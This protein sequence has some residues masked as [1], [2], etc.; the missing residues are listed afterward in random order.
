[1]MTKFYEIARNLG[2]DEDSTQDAAISLLS[3]IRAGKEINESY[4]K[5]CLWLRT[6]DNQR[7]SQRYLEAMETAEKATMPSLCEDILKQQD[8]NKH[9]A[10]ELVDRVLERVKIGKKVTNKFVKKILHTKKL[11]DQQKKE[12]LEAMFLKILKKESNEHSF[13]P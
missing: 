11:T 3:N 13:Q 9:T 7:K 1:M 10:N 4:M 2:S 8:S 5:K 12:A 6:K